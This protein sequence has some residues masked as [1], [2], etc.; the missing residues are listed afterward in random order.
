MARADSNTG[1]LVFLHV[2]MV[3]AVFH[4]LHTQNTMLFNAMQYR[5]FFQGK[6]LFHREIHSLLLH[7]EPY[8]LSNSVPCELFILFIVAWGNRVY[9][10]IGKYKLY[11][12]QFFSSFVSRYALQKTVAMMTQLGL[13]KWLANQQSTLATS[14]T[15]CTP[16][17]AV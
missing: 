4:R 8:S 2:T 14:L 3:I 1:P 15:L 6:L 12:Q 13:I 10:S 17:L 7:G 5:S 9:C 11:N 16:R